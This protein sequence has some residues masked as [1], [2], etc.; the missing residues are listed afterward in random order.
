MMGRLK[1]PDSTDKLTSRQRE[2]LSALTSLYVAHGQAVSYE[3][4]A[5]EMKVSK[6]TAY[7]ILHDLYERG[8]LRLQHA[9]TPGRGRSRVLYAPEWNLGVPAPR[10]QSDG[11]TETNALAWLR[12]KVGQYSMHTTSDSMRIIARAI[13]GEGNPFR[14]VLFVCVLFVL[15]AGAFEV[16]IEQLI[17]VRR[18][19][20]STLSSGT[21][22]SVLGE[23]MFS[24]MCDEQWLMEKLNLPPESISQ[25]AM[26]EQSFR[27]SMTRLSEGDRRVMVSVVR[28]AVMP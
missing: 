23:A 7:D 17:H 13:I 12:E 4:V 3:D 14:V 28:K 8:F 25:F 20:T 1:T 6:W 16:D 18:F 26:C 21:I 10:Q 2:F 27:S 11:T 9:L 15:F 22:L 5:D 19:V 24:M